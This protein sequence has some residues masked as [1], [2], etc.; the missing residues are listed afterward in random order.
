MP[1]TCSNCESAASIAVPKSIIQDTTPFIYTPSPHEASI[2]QSTLSQVHRDIAQLDDRLI[3]LNHDQELLS[4]KREALVTYAAKHATLLCPIQR[5]PYELLAD[6]F[7]RCMPPKVRWPSTRAKLH[8]VAPSHTCRRWRNVAL[9]TPA[10]W[11]RMSF[12]LRDS[13]TQ[14]QKQCLKDMILRMGASR[15]SLVIKCDLDLK[16]DIIGTASSM[17]IEHSTQWRL[18]T[19]PA[20][21]RLIDTQPT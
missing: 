3:H 2:I 12:D 7:I 17:L 4:S 1:T 11:S 10:L 6:I 5:L 16:D 8:T 20:N 13:S 19:R 9:S 14:S 21:N 15:L 18:V